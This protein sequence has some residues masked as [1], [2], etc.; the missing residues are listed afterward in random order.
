MV[1]HLEWLGT[2]RPGDVHPHKVTVV[3]TRVDGD[4]FTVVYRQRWSP[5]LLGRRGDTAAFCA[6]FRP[7]LT[8]KHLAQIVLQALSEPEDRGQPGPPS[9]AEG[10]VADPT[11]V[12]WLA[13]LE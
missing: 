8:P 9:W 3:A 7:R 6:L 5:Q 13:N 11:A 10:L 4:R 12:S 2:S 1:C